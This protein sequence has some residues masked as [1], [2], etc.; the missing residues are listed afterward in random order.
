MIDVLY[1]VGGSLFDLPDLADRLRAVFDAGDGM[2]LVIVGGGAAANL[3]RDWDQRFQLGDERAHRLAMRSLRL[4][5]HL[6]QSLL[7]GSQIVSSRNEA[8]VSVAQ[9]RTPILCAEKFLHTEEPDSSLELPHTWDVTSDS[10]AVWIS[11]LR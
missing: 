10:I 8:H 9:G 11:T 2:A 1:K 3:V 7:P 6:L 5:V 4:N